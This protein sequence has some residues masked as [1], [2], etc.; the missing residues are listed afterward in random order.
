MDT[1]TPS[2]AGRSK[3]A[4]LFQHSQGFP[5]AVLLV[6]TNDI[7][8]NIVACYCVKGFIWEVQLQ[9]VTL[10]KTDIGHALYNGFR[11]L[12]LAVMGKVLCRLI[13]YP[14]P[15][16]RPIAAAPVIPLSTFFSAAARRRGSSP[17]VLSFY[18]Q[19]SYLFP[20]IAS[21]SVKNYLFFI[22]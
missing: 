6:C 11:Q 12:Q 20:F 2:S 1:I 10:L 18:S 22:V 3:D 4:A 16:V 8:I 7:M 17:W 13:N 5:Q 9:G 15:A 21:G 19:V 14:I